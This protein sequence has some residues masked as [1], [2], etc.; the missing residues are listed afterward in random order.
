M[1]RGGGCLHRWGHSDVIPSLGQSVYMYMC[2]H[3]H[4]YMCHLPPVHM[5][6]PLGYEIHVY[7]YI[8]VMGAG[9]C[10]H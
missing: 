4:M 2:M 10:V 3:V 9:M 8:V 1:K 6:T 7:A 5:L